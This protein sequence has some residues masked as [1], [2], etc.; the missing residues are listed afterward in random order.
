MRS[1]GL[2]GVLFPDVESWL[3]IEEEGYP[4]TFL[5][6][7]FQWIENEVSLNKKVSPSLLFAIILSGPIELRARHLQ[8]E[9]E[10]K[11]P[12]VFPAVKEII[13]HL[14][15]RISIPKRDTEAIKSILY[16]LQRFPQTKGKRPYLWRKNPNFTDAYRYFKL[17]SEIDGDN[18]ELIEWWD[19]FLSSGK[20]WTVKKGSRNY[21]GKRGRGGKGKKSSS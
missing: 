19:A 1:T 8:E 2:F 16:G 10:A 12:V 7:A 13:E 9:T 20:E 11:N 21:Y 5:G 6:R 3:S 4:H 14:R 18:S 15:E 17:K